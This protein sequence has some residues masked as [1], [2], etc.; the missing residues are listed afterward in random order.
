M[1][2]REQ[3]LNTYRDSTVVMMNECRRWWDRVTDSRLASIPRETGIIIARAP[4]RA[5]LAACSHNFRRVVR[6][7]ALI[8]RQSCLPRP[9][10]VAALSRTC[11]TFYTAFSGRTTSVFILLCRSHNEY[12]VFCGCVIASD[13]EFPLDGRTASEIR[14]QKMF[15]KE[16]KEG[17]RNQVSGR[18]IDVASYLSQ[19]HRHGES[20]SVALILKYAEI[21]VSSKINTRPNEAR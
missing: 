18:K 16:E 4:A 19:L 8:E 14:G 1:R 20:A 2:G 12:L 10:P 21:Y 9:S 13:A 17:K 6:C 5:S 15:G 7:S 11:S 3:S